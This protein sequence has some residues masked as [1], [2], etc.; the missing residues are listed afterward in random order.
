[1]FLDSLLYDAC[2]ENTKSLNE[3]AINAD[4][5]YNVS[6]SKQG[7]AKRYTPAAIKYIQAIIG[8]VLSHQINRSIDLGWFK[9]FKRVPI[10]DSTKFDVSENLEGQ[11]PGFG[12]SA[13]KAG[14]GIQYEFDIKSGEVTDLNI[15]PAN[16]PDSKDATQT[17]DKVREGD[18]LIRDLG[19]SVLSVFSSIVQN[20][21]YFISRLN[22]NIAVYE[23]KGGKLVG[24]DFDKLYKTMA[25]GKIQRVDKQVSIGKKDKLPV[26][27]IIELMPEEVV[28]KRMRKVN[29][30]NKKKGFRTS[31][32]YSSRARFN[33]F[34]TNIP[35]T[36]MEAGVVVQIYKIRWQVELIFKAWKSIFGIDNVNHM[37]YERFMCLLNVRLLLIVINWGIFIHKR[38]QVYTKTKKLLSITKCF[39]TFQEHNKELRDILTNNCKGLVKW[40]GMITKLFESH[41]LLE[42]KKNKVGLAE[43]MMLKHLKTEYYD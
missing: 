2:S 14:V 13:S 37:K 12:G 23:E 18:L 38:S 7:I 36:T 10:K 33:L 30:Y 29:K 26:R 8:Q 43:I 4:K 19:Y 35:E 31:D 34:I 20:K 24:L 41:H 39:K 5:K 40:I 22:Y 42:K 16:R 21:A 3:I 1:M 6:I 32:E 11:L 15:T 28:E 27:L 25:K 17:K 9:L